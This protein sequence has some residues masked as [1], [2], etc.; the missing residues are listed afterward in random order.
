MRQAL[1]SGEPD[2]PLPRGGPD[3]QGKDGVKQ[4]K[5]KSGA[6]KSSGCEEIE[7]VLA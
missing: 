4:R 1:E 2:L 7:V 3:S 5:Q 6:H